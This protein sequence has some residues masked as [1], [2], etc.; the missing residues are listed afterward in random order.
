MIAVRSRLR[1]SIFKLLGSKSLIF[2]CGSL[3]SRARAPHWTRPAGGTAA[4]KM[5]SRTK[6]CSRGC[7]KSSGCILL[8]LCFFYF[9]KH[10]HWSI[11]FTCKKYSKQ[12]EP[13]YR[14]QDMGQNVFKSPSWLDFVIFE[15]QNLVILAVLL[16]KVRKNQKTTFWSMSAWQSF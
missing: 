12:H 4:Q 5:K 7:N 8:V 10:V 11:R 16:P 9:V 13:D 15:P 3:L 6:T 1:G 14:E 2:C